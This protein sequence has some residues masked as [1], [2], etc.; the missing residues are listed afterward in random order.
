MNLRSITM[1]YKLST[2]NIDLNKEG[3]LNA[4]ENVYYNTLLGK[5]AVIPKDVDFDNPSEDLK[6]F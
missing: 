4:K 1:N 3:Y 5:F 2:F 6:G